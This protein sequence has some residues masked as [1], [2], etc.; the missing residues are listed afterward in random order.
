VSLIVTTHKQ[1]F[2]ITFVQGWKSSTLILDE[3]AV[4]RAE[5]ASKG[6][7]S[8]RLRFMVVLGNV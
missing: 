1:A 4:E 2:L 3:D 5:K 7:D 8:G 6:K